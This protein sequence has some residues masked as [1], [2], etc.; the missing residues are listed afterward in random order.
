L[1]QIAGKAI[2]SRLPQL[3]TTLRHFQ[4]RRATC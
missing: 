2:E 4:N 3:G 1:F